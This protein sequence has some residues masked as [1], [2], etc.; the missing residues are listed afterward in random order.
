MTKIKTEE[1]NKIKATIEIQTQFTTRLGDTELQILNL[2]ETKTNILKKIN[3]LIKE[4]N[5]Y[6]ND[7]KDTYGDGTLNIDTGEFTVTK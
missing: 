7:L 4:R 3:D 2:K 1:L 6:L 5:Q